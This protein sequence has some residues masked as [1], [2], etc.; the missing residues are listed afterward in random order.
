MNV[1]ARCL[2]LGVTA[3]LLTAVGSVL[4]YPE[5]ALLG[6][7][8]LTVVGYAA[9][10]ALWQPR[11][12]VR[13]TVEPDRVN[14]GDACTVTLQVG[15][16]RRWGV[17]SVLAEERCG[18]RWIPV[19]L[20][21][22]RSGA[23]TTV[24]YPVPTNR[25]GV[26]PVGPLRVLRRDPFGLVAVARA[27]GEP[28][29]VWIRPQVHPLR[30]VPAGIAR[31][32]D[33]Q[34]DRVPHGSITFDSLREYVVGDELRRVHWRTSARIGQLM[35]REHVDTSLPRMVVLLDN[36][37][38][39]YHD[40]ADGASATFES[41]CEAAASVVDAATR[42]DLPVLLQMVVDQPPP[43]DTP[44]RHPLDRLAEVTLAGTNRLTGGDP[45]R[46]VC[47]QL[48]Q[49]RP[50]DTLIYLAGTG[51]PDAVARIGGLRAVFA[52]VL[53]GRITGAVDPSAVGAPAVGAPT[54]LAGVLFVEADDG[55][56]FA[57]GWD[58]AGDR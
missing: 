20:T 43:D 37:T 15:N 8:G 13:R 9:G 7:A 42:A 32:L 57:A 25:R 27:D 18:R 38:A 14:R 26:L 28:V 12:W 35:V 39:A 58:A 11:L 55:V 22:L 23:T 44:S 19:P 30:A 1:T 34:I 3:A 29:R 31:S 56:G 40:Q 48:R 52:S 41:A 24:R 51:D 4:G 50:G 5:L 36:R 46:Q 53:V 10:Y 17:A 45:V 16:L 47:D 6:T 49:Q 2:G 54:G 21:Q 33:G